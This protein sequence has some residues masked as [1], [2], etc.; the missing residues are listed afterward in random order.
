MV[1]VFTIFLVVCQT[2]IILCPV[3]Y[4]TPAMNNWMPLIALAVL[5]I[6]QLALRGRSGWGVLS[7]IL[8]VLFGLFSIV[9]LLAAIFT[10]F[11]YGDRESRVTPAAFGRADS[12]KEIA[13][14]YHPGGSDLTRRVISVIAEKMAQNG[15]K[16]TLYAAN[17]GLMM[18][19]GKVWAIG[20]ASPVY[21]SSIRPPLA[22]FIQRTDL[23]GVRC[24]A[25]I[26][27]WSHSPEVEKVKGLIESKGGIYLDG[28]KFT[29]ADL[30]QTGSIEA[31][32]DSIMDKLR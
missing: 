5:W 21:G 1:W 24:F 23:A 4:R 9:G 15:I 25:I 30:K 22:E 26:T 3:I 18:D 19:P 11:T 16:V 6:N 13:I 20:F 32:A 31:L 8:W 27:G 10:C 14:V 12:S 7:V 28:G 29:A 17:S 2:V